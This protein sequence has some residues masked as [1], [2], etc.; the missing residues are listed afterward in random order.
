MITQFA[1]D[2]L[3]GLS[4]TP[5]TL[6]SKYFYD[7]KGDRI[8]QKIMNL[9]EYY[10]T[11]CEYEIL[12]THQ[13]Q[14]R[15]LFMEGT[16][17]FNLVEFG[18]GD[19]FKTKVLLECFLNADV[20]FRYRPIDISGNVLQILEESLEEEFPSL[21]VEGIQNEYMKALR[22]LENGGTR[23]VV[24]FLGS[25]IGNFKHSQ[26]VTF[27]KGLYEGLNEG[28]LL[29][30]GFDLKKDPEVILDAYNDKSGVTRDFNLNLLNR[31][32][33]E[34][35]GNF[36]LSAFRHFPTYDPLTGTTT[37]YLV[38]T[39][40]QTVEIMDTAVEFDPWEAI[41]M[42]ISQKYSMKDIESLATQVG[43]SIVRNF[44]DAKRYFVNSVWRK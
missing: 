32:N 22:E 4:A 35:K 13:H 25:N 27:L 37:S 23:N 33:R 39:K 17:K 29:F 15:D 16:S 6:S 12:E 31:I 10:L 21:K 19:G 36:D 38:S 3:S 7:E 34:L 9:E 43:F 28:D 44:Y 8:F 40:A 1:Q 42:E 30:I 2:V 26:A 24:L 11:K 20:D 41:H 18:A 14:I 5:K